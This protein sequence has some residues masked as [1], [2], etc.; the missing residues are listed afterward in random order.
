[1]SQAVILTAFVIIVLTT[2]AFVISRSMIE[3]SV[4]TNL[5]SIASIAEDAIEANL[6][7]DRERAGL[8]SAHSDIKAI[9]AGNASFPT[10][11]RLLAQ[12]QRDQESLI[13]ME[14]YDAEGIILARAGDQI[15]LVPDALRIPVYHPVIDEKGWEYYDVFTPVWIS[16]GTRIGVL[17]LRYKADSALVPLLS[18]VPSLGDT[19]QTVLIFEQNGELQLLHP[20]LD[21]EKSYILSLGAVSDLNPGLALLQAARGKEGVMRSDDY[22]GNDT[23][24]AFR[25]LPTLGWGMAIQV[26][27][28]AALIDVRKLAI[29]HASIGTMILILAAA[30]AYILA[31]QLTA[32]LRELTE[33]VSHLR[34]GHWQIRHTVHSGDEVELLD[35]VVVDLSTRLRNIYERLEQEVQA[36]TEQLRKQFALDRAI[37]ENID[38]GVITVDRRGTITGINPAAEILLGIDGE[39]AEG[40]SIESVMELSTN[41]GTPV[42]GIHPVRQCLRSGKVVH[43]PASGKLNVRKADKKLL[44]VMFAVSPLHERSKLFGAIV[45]LQDIT[46]ASHIDSLKS[47][48]I[49][50]ASH[51][52][53]TPLSA[54][55][56]YVELFQGEKKHL[57]DNQ[58]SYLHEMEH[59]TIRMVALLS[60]LLQTARLEE[61][62][63]HPVVQMVD[64]SE[65]MRELQADCQTLA[66][67]EGLKCSL[68]SPRKAVRISTD[69]TL[70]RIVLQNL[71]INAVKYS[72]KGKKNG[73][74]IL[75]M[76]ETKKNVQI[77][78]SDEGIGIPKGEQ[79]RIFQKFFRAKNVRR[80]DTDGSGLGLYITRSILD[81]LGASVEFHSIENEGT[82][83]TVTFPKKIVIRKKK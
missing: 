47:E 64:M 28:Q 7:R 16:G 40:R 3:R 25:Y 71:M 74:V 9:L 37:L 77:S 21:E 42:T 44:P 51:Q 41:R 26:D 43:S 30:L 73:H 39:G 66:N 81:R 63:V 31:H 8:L 57:T 50:L 56:W 82:I 22:R 70:V 23:L 34:P 10:L 6:Q 61:D 62:D 32:P 78:I 48:F 45:V 20:D 79:S 35:R 55:R 53:R 65:L 69:P 2:L 4:R 75:N 27:R 29:S 38:Y 49:S 46:E 52:L 59:A 76:K 83:F 24:V 19:A 67:G 18:V 12:I 1:M 60:S 68:D 11:E 13:A 36:R 72:L 5:S 58:K 15:G 14:V 80:M 17:A 33:K 54:I